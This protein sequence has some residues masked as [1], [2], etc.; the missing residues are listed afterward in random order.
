MTVNEAKNILGNRAVWEL[1]HMIR[2]L[3]QFSFLNN[4]EDN[5]RLKACR[6]LLKH[7]T[8]GK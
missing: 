2:A 7:L 3:N 4:E 1:R 8:K 6:V 5:L